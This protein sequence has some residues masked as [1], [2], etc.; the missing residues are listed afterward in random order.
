MREPLSRGGPPRRV[1]GPQTRH[2]RDSTYPRDGNRPEVRGTPSYLTMC[3]AQNRDS[4][5]RY[6]LLICWKPEYF[7]GLGVRRQSVCPYARLNTAIERM[8]V[9]VPRDS[10]N[11]DDESSR[12]TG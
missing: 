11:I 10:G 6:Q 5:E 1:P 12:P 2:I 8:P 9:P 3:A 7:P 4:Q